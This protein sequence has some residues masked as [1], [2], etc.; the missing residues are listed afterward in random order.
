MI[1]YNT[2]LQKSDRNTGKE[3]STIAWEECFTLI[4]EK[5]VS[6]NQMESTAIEFSSHNVKRTGRK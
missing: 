4:K 5:Y 3:E 2:G 1:F 6:M